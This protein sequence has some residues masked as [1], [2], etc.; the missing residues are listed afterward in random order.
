MPEKIGKLID[1]GIDLATI[2]A[3]YKNVMASTLELNPQS[4]TLD[5]PTLRA[6]ISAEKEVPIYDFE[7]ALRK[8][9]RW[10]YT[11]NAKEEVA[12][13]TKK[14]LQDFGFMG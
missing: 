4:I 3:P 14:I 10:Q 11:N 13:A 6:A 9:T 7:R 5:D 2:Y 12:N 8:D 1:Q